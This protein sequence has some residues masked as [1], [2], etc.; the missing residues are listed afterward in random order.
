ML[1][2]VK[3]Y[4]NSKVN[5]IEICDDFIKVYVVEIP[6]KGKANKAMIRLLADEFGVSP[7]KI[8]IKNGETSNFKL[9][10]IGDVSE[11]KKR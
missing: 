6:E 1:K 3:V 8:K 7:S 2:D 10:E 9:I 5:K 11:D 4:T